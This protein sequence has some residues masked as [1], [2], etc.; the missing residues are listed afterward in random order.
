MDIAKSITGYMNKKSILTDFIINYPTS[1]SSKLGYNLIFPRMN[2]ILSVINDSLSRYSNPNDKVLQTLVNRVKL[3]MKGGL[4]T[5]IYFKKFMEKIR[6]DS[7]DKKT[8]QD[9]TSKDSDYDSTIIFKPALS[10][11]EGKVFD[12]PVNWKK[13]IVLVFS[14]IETEI[15]TNQILRT[16]VGDLSRELQKNIIGRTDGGRLVNVNGKFYNAIPLNTVKELYD[17]F[18]DRPFTFEFKRTNSTISYKDRKNLFLVFKSDD[19]L[20]WKDSPVVKED[21]LPSS[22]ALHFK[23]T[24][25]LD[26]ETGPTFLLAR[27]MGCMQIYEIDPKN[28]LPPTSVIVTNNTNFTY[29]FELLDTSVDTPYTTTKYESKLGVQEIKTD[30]GIEYY[31][32]N[33]GALVYDN[34][35]IFLQD[36]FQKVKK[37]CNRLIIFLRVYNLIKSSMFNNIIQDYYY[38]FAPN[39]PL[40]DKYKV[41]DTQLSTDKNFR[42][43]IATQYPGYMEIKEVETVIKE[44]GLFDTFIAK[45]I[46]NCLETKNPEIL[47]FRKQL[48]E[49]FRG[50]Q[51]VFFSDFIHNLVDY[52]DMVKDGTLERLEFERLKIKSPKDVDYSMRELLRNNIPTWEEVS[53]QMQQIYGGTIHLHGGVK[54][55]EDVKRYIQ[56]SDIYTNVPPNMRDILDS[57]NV[58]PNMRDILDRIITLVKNNI[59]MSYDIDTFTIG[60]DIKRM[61]TVLETKYNVVLTQPE[62]K[63]WEIIKNLQE[64]GIYKAVSYYPPA[65]KPCAVTT[66]DAGCYMFF[67]KDNLYTNKYFLPYTVVRGNVLMRRKSDDLYYVAN[68]IDFNVVDRNNAIVQILNKNVYSFQLC[69]MLMLDS[70]L[71]TTDEYGYLTNLYLRTTESKRRN[72]LIRA[73]FYGAKLMRQYGL[74]YSSGSDYPFLKLDEKINKK[75]TTSKIEGLLDLRFMTDKHRTIILTATDIESILS[76]TESVILD[77]VVVLPAA[78]MDI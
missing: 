27:I 2:F 61:D 39:M 13:F 59:V 21:T 6:F 49:I 8:L 22:N 28:E 76:F 7:L 4:V 44:K 37:R 74:L 58:P 15:A 54:F 72:K 75:I 17:I 26:N 32:L 43:Q 56:E 38:L 12:D 55:I 1:P 19:E 60:S 66:A 64:S 51:V 14:I 62:S 41:L 9:L 77:E 42:D 20:M 31:T 10:D 71:I 53:R 68:T 11:D 46:D 35:K 50:P 24:F 78:R 67:Y 48:I 5:N 16:T 65:A 70:S 73:V 3:A 36:T 30:T 23:H 57:T 18:P 25:L 69:I 40:K 33:L 47:S 45:I 29:H 63:E 34:Y 52:F